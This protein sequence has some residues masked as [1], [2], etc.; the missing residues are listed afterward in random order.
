VTRDERPVSAV[1]AWTW[2]LLA[3][4]LACQ[5]ALRSS[6]ADL[7][8]SARGLP[9][10]PQAA[11]LRIAS[12][13]EPAALARVM[14]LYLQS[15]DLGGSSPAP[16][17]EFDYRQLTAW[18]RAILHADPRSEYPLFLAARL[19]AENPDGAKTRRMLEFIHDEY[20]LDPERRWPWLAH[21]ALVA[22]HRL[23][24]LGLARR[25]AAEVARLSTGDN[26]PS[27]VRQME[28]FILEDM[29]ELEAAKVLLGGM[30]A[31]GRIRDPAERRFLQG[32]LEEL[33]TRLQTGPGRKNP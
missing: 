21:A 20:L 13:G 18:L 6:P 27:W 16:Y 10:A 14:M 23:K 33:E 19:Y 22:K 5:V 17:R 25:Y 4:T 2:T 15:I 29:N 3:A 32:K 30:L 24:D 31:S 9:P 8:D 11:A 1:P 26:V 28:V 7:D 12:L